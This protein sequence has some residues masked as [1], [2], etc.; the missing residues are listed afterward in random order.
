[1]FIPDTNFSHP[2]PRIPDPESKRFPDPS[3]ESDMHL[4]PDLIV[5]TASLWHLHTAPEQK[6]RITVS[7]TNSN[8]KYVFLLLIIFKGA[9]KKCCGYGVFI[10][11][12][13]SRIPDPTTSTKEEWGKNLLSFL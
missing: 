6:F 1:M 7:W 5:G 2:G 11:D 9:V 10:P 3:F 12:A 4:D 8:S 13:G